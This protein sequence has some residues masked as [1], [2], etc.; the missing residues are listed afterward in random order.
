MA[1]LKRSLPPAS[2]GVQQPVLMV[3]MVLNDIAK[4]DDVPRT[5]YMGILTAVDK[6]P[7]HSLSSTKQNKPEETTQTANENTASR[8]RSMRRLLQKDFDEG[9]GAEWYMVRSSASDCGRAFLP[10][11]IPAT[12]KRAP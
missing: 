10:M 4:Q 9:R 2:S 11:M 7:I 12:I 1:R 8:C 6:P 5:M 3:S